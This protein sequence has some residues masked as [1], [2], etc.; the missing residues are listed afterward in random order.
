MFKRIF[1]ANRGEVAVRIIRTCRDLGVE[2]VIGYAEPDRDSMAVM[3]ADQAVCIGPAALAESYLDPDRLLTV[4]VA[5]GCEAVHPGYGFLSENARFA[6]AVVEEGLIYIGPSAAVIRQMGD[7][8]AARKAMV[9]AG[10]P[11]IPGSEGAVADEAVAQAFGDAHGYPLLFKA[12]AG[13]GGRGMRVVD[14][15]EALS[16]AFQDATR[17]AAAA[18]G[19]GRLYME[20]FITS[21]KHVEVQIIAD[22][23]G[24]VCHI[25][26]R[27]CSLQRKQQKLMEE[28]P[29][30]SL[31]PVLREAMCGA[32]VK[33]A[34]SVGYE[35]VGTV[36][37]LVTD[38][39]QW[40]FMEMNTRLQ[41][42]HP[43]TELVS[44]IDLVKEQLRIASGQPL[45][46]VQDDIVLR[47]H[48]IE[49]RINAENPLAGFRPSVGTV[50]GVHLPT[51]PFVRVDTALMEGS[52]VSVYYDSL[53]A[54]VS[55]WGDTRLEAMR[56]MR[57]ALAEMVLEGIDTTMELHYMLLHHVDVVRGEYH[58]RF[59]DEHLDELVNIL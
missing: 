58:S 19:D 57:R 20:R 11:V 8:I 41:V 55:V 7:K 53:V 34:A 24:H 33:A 32:A 40:Y 6:E 2:T 25:G 36:E 42:E 29:C 44:G 21:A 39:G 22:R 5:T 48:A 38:A 28:T 13:G 35:G 45:D 26:E 30:R 43:I 31:D 54:K 4:A 18:F 56:R 3:M 27:D 12:A 37:F 59:I 10:I 52:D 46:F 17:E 51:G 1:I 49:C 15:A 23:Q 14:S 16:G 9:A 50:T 47:G